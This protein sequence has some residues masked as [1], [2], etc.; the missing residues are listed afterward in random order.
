MPKRTTRKRDQDGIFERPDSPFWW[1]TWTDAHGRTV[2]RSTHVRREDD[3]RKERAKALRAQWV[4]EAAEERERGPKPRKAAGPTFDELMV[5]YLDGP[6]LDKRS[7]ER[8]LYSFK[9]LAPTFQGRELVD[10]TGADARGYIAQ[11]QAA[12]ISAATINKEIGL[13]SAALNWARSDLEWKVPNPFQSRRLAE[14]PG[15]DRW[16]TQDE[17]AALIH[18]AENLPRAGHLADFIR[19]GLYTGLR[20]GEILSLE[21]RRVDLSRNLILF[22]ADNQKNGKAGSVPVNAKAREAILARARFRATW[23]PASPWVFADRE[24]NRI[25]SVKKSFHAARDKAGLG[26]DVTPHTLRRTFGSWLA[27]AGQPIQAISAL[28]RHSDIRVTDR[29]YAHLSPDSLRETA[30]V[31]DGG[32]VSRSGFTLPDSS[33]EIAAK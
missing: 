14:P 11:R 17:A 27:Q 9:Q 3:P 25:A 31:L 22:G 32:A 33:R 30:A 29:V 15:R 12:G 20:P 13:F 28:L 19:I 10:L 6:S 16:L 8:D 2:R 1:A 18:A 26:K 5:A 24:G 21:W 7:H 4:V 23:C